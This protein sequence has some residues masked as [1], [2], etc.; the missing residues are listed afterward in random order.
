MRDIM[1]SALILTIL[2][3]VARTVLPKIKIFVKW[4]IKVCVNFAEKKI[5]GSGLG[6]QKKAKVLKWL[7]WFGI[8]ANSFINEL[9]ENAVDVMNSKKSDVKD[10]I[11]DDITDGIE[12]V[13][14]NII[15]KVK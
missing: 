15:D 6:E 12:N 8:S 4:I 7:K 14:T 5:K 1:L 10:D 13:T 11:V 9:I 3:I 2:S